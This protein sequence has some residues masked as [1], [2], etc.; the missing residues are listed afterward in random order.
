MV[1][2]SGDRHYPDTKRRNRSS[3]VGNTSMIEIVA[4]MDRSSGLCRLI[5]FG[6]DLFQLRMFGGAKGFAVVRVRSGPTQGVLEAR[7]C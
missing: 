3:M 7:H 6:L 2:T 1:A 5:L 4:H